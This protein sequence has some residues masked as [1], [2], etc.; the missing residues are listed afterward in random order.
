LILLIFI[1]WRRGRAGY[2][3]LQSW[4]FC[5]VAQGAGAGHKKKQAN[6]TLLNKNAALL[7]FMLL[8]IWAIVRG[9]KKTYKTEH[10]KLR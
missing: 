2:T 3:A 9:N 7:T 6:L 1:E 5:A 4:R 8:P 10:K